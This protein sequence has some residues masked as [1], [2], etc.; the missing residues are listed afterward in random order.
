MDSL[1]HAIVLGMVSKE[2]DIGRVIEGQE[3]LAGIT[4]AEGH[5]GA[6]ADDVIGL[7]KIVVDVNVIVV[8]THDRRAWV[9]V[10]Y[11]QADP[12]SGSGREQIA[13]RGGWN[14]D[15]FLGASGA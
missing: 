15:D 11:A 12:G 3:R 10:E 5:S 8:K 2:E 6:D 14:G 4:E 7:F 9:K 1:I 13:G